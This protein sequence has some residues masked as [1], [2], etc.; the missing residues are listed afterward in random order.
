MVTA[1]GKWDLMSSEWI[2]TKFDDIAS[3]QRVRSNTTQREHGN[4][5][6]TKGKAELG[7]L[8]RVLF[9]SLPNFCK[10]LPHWV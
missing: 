9:S 3:Y 2:E 10:F 4:L 6:S 1:A 5:V 8:L 7:F